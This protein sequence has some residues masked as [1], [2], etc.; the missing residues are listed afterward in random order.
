MEKRIIV[1]EEDF[2]M[3]Y[4]PVEERF[5][6]IFKGIKFRGKGS[7]KAIIDYLRRNSEWDLWGVIVHPR[8]VL[9]VVSPLK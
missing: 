9:E 5:E 7:A 6:G 3:L 2:V 1:D 8:F 4:N